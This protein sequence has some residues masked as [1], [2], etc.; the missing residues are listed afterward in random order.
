MCFVFYLQ[1]TK[2]NK[3]RMRKQKSFLTGSVTQVTLL[4]EAYRTK[5]NQNF[6]NLTKLS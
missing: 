6:V 5:I 2:R 3:D 4:K 1:V